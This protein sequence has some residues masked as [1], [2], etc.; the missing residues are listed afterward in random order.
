MRTLDR[1]HA[2]KP[3]ILKKVAKYRVN[4]M[5]ITAILFDKIQHSKPGEGP[6]LIARIR[7][8]MKCSVSSRETAGAKP[9]TPT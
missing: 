1:P 4:L 7:S 5:L 2:L 3:T 8:K 9:A 6:L